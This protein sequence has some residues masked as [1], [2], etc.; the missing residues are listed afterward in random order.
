MCLLRH[1]TIQE[2]EKK[3]QKSASTDHPQK[4]RET[5]V[6]IITFI[7]YY[8]LSDDGIQVLGYCESLSEFLFSII[9]SE[10]I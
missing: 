10:I 6:S 5:W 7:E 1:Q 4:S 9:V 2:I 3:Q 8:F